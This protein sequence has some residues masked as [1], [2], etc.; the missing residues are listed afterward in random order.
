MQQHRAVPG[1]RAGNAGAVTAGTLWVA[2]LTCERDGARRISPGFWRLPRVLVAFDPGAVLVQGIEGEAIPVQRGLEP[3]MRAQRAGYGQC[4]CEGLEREQ[5]R[6]GREEHEVR[7]RGQ[8]AEEGR[9]RRGAV[10]CGS[11]IA[12]SAAMS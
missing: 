11:T 8:R 3:A 6:P 5:V 1:L 2:A 10:T 4:R 12:V 7:V 9:R